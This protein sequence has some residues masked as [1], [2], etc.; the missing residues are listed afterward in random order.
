MYILQVS[1]RNPY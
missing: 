1:K